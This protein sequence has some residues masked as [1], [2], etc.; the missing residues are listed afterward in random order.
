MTD[1][2]L[3]AVWERA[4]EPFRLEEIRRP[5][6]RRGEALVRVSS[7][8]VCHTDLHVMK[9][10][11][12]FPAPAVLGHE[13]SGQVVELG[14]DTT[15]TTVQVGRQVVGAFI[16][17]CGSCRACGRGRDDMCSEFFGQ[18]RLRGVL[19]DGSTRLYRTDGTPLAMYSMAGFAEYAVV[20][21]TALAPLPDGLD[22]E[23]AAVLGCAGLTAYGAVHNAAALQAGETVVVVA[24]GGVGSSIIQLAKERGAT[25]VIAVDVDADKL[26][27]ARGLGADH[28]VNSRDTDPVSAVQ[29][30]LGGR[31]ADVVFEV[32]GLPQTFEQ[33]VRMVGDGGRMVAV[34]I[35]AGAASAAVE[36]TPLVRRGVRIIG[37]FGARTR[38]DLP[39]VVGSAATGALSLPDTVTRRYP[40]ERVNEA[41]TD[42]RDGR[43]R[44]RAIVH[45]GENA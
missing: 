23:S 21:V 37:S 15:S 2:M 14:P 16:M 18:N 12:N 13:I 3:A 8:G 36:I 27:A 4:D 40:L 35:A 24:V 44:G 33:A 38:V 30:I 19:Y 26:T 22:A 25:T 45:M 41:F 43:I 42:L 10:E 17:P 34:G 32:L 11:V 39:A 1:T 5:S 20:P 29:D 9:G 31:G 6:P 28:V 7:C